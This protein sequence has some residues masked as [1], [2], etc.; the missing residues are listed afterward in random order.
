MNGHVLTYFIDLRQ[1]SSTFGELEKIE[2]PVGISRTFV[3]PEGIAH[4][5]L[6]II[7]SEVLYLSDRA[8][9]PS[10]DL[11]VHPLSVEFEWPHTPK[12]LSKRDASLPT[13]AEYLSK[14]S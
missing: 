7:D 6:A 4:G 10:E 3:V 2:T 5:F 14:N 11:G 12:G 9:N 8:H 13:L 1:N